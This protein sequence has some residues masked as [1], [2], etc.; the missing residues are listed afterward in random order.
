MSWSRIW[1]L[2]SRIRIELRQIGVGI[3]QNDRRQVPAAGYVL[4]HLLGDFEPVSIKMAKEQNL[5]LNPTKI[6]GICGRLMCCLK[7][8][9][10]LYEERTV[11]WLSQG[12]GRVVESFKAGLYL[13]ATPIGNLEDITLRVIRLF[14]GEAILIAA[15][16]T[17]KTRKL[18]THYNLH[19]PLV[20]YHQHNWRQRSGE[21][22][23]KARL[24]PV[25]VV[26]DAGMPGISDPGSELVQ[27][28]AEAQIPV[29]VLPG[30]SAAF[31]AL[32]LSGLATDRFSFEGF[33]P[34]QESAR[35]ALL[36]KLA[37]EEP[38]M[39]FMKHHTGSS[40]QPRISSSWAAARC[41]GQGG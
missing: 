2:I 32:V 16:D 40:R 13:C 4:R 23:A 8:E 29:T 10:K 26:S 19:K 17:R 37:L 31:T 39:I 30:A 14:E 38:D 12:R 21:L 1:L 7:F 27:L 28:A 34:R 24:G 25:A 22:L 36:E 18:L 15:E 5:S 11:S 35:R 20:S 33:L 9:S 3:R 41:C 6:S